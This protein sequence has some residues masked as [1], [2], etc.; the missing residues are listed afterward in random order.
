[1]VVIEIAADLESQ[2]EIVSEVLHPILVRRTATAHSVVDPHCCMGRE[3]QRS[4]GKL[5]TVPPGSVEEELAPAMLGIP[6]ASRKSCS[7][8]QHEARSLLGASAGIS[9]SR[10]PVKPTRAVTPKSDVLLL[11]IS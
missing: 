10:P 9:R 8:T 7:P 3:M 6:A 2:L 11:P 4:R 5:C 1:M